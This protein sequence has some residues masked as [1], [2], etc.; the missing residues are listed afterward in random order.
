LVLSLILS[1]GLVALVGTGSWGEA[2]EMPL[3]PTLPFGSF[4]LRMGLSVMIEAGFQ[5]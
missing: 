5:L 2:A 4:S 1:F 3:L